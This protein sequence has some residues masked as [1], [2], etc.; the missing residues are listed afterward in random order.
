MTALA[1]VSPGQCGIPPVLR[2]IIAAHRRWIQTNGRAGE[3]AELRD[4]DLRDMDLTG[5]ELSGADLS[6][7]DLR[8][9]CLNRSQFRLATMRGVHLD[10]ASIN[11]VHF[12]GANLDRAVFDRAHVTDSRFDPIELVRGDGSTTHGEVAV[13]LVGVRFRK[14]VI[15]G[16]SFRNADLRAVKFDQAELVDCDFEGAY[17]EPAAR[18]KAM[19]SMCRTSAVAS[20]SPIEA[21]S[22]AAFYAGVGLRRANGENRYQ[23]P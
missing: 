6:G 20:A 4:F 7:A 2:R 16:S 19:A 15:S 18:D 22:L 3:R 8:G 11:Q 5:V 1:A 10:G 17:L 21:A 13:R 14:A 12:D 23:Q 9:A